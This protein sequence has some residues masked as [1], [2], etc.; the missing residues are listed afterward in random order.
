MDLEFG[1][2]FIPRI[3]SENYKAV[4]R[5]LGPTDLFSAALNLPWAIVD[6]AWA[7]KN[8]G[9]L[10]ALRAQDT[11]ILLDGSWW[12]Y[13]YEPTF[14]VKRMAST[15]W[16]PDGPLSGQS[17]DQLAR[18]VRESIRAQ[19]KLDA[20]AY[21]VPGLL[22]EHRHE[23][24]RGSYQTIIKVA[25]E[26]DDVPPKPLVLFVGAHAD[27][28]DIAHQILDELPGFL[29]GIYLQVAPLTPVKDSPSKLLR[30]TELYLHARELGLPVIAGHAGA[31]APALRAAGIDAAD[32]GLAS[33]EAFQAAGHRRAKPPREEGKKQSGGASS[34]MY[35][36]A[37]GQSFASARVTEMR[38]VPAARDLLGACRLPC[39]R[40]I[41]GDDYLSRAQEHSLRARITE[42]VA[43]A[44]RP[45]SMRLS[46]VIDTVTQRRSTVTALNAALQA[47]GIAPIDT[48]PVDNHLNWLGRL[49]ERRTA[50]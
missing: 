10:A 16:A 25:G 4:D 35:L 22:P 36:E 15:S 43:I 33:S 49:A 46:E 26:F 19:A 30:V 24:L 12:R 48:R 14:A 3:G 44:S 17:P 45:P 21:F 27:G 37:I 6:A 28:L 20:D 31:A 11:G 23:D 47:A 42:A 32:A 8:Q 1:H 5:C 13:R 2:G 41:G 18:F 39:H 34:R 40:F 50:A 29:S 38:S 9:F 7:E